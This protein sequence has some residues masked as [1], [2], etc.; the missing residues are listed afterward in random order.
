MVLMLAGMGAASLVF[1]PVFFLLHI[2]GIEVFALPAARD[3]PLFVANN[4]LVVGTNLSFALCVGIVSPLFCSIAS[5]LALPLTSVVDY[6]LHGIRFSTSK[7]IGTGAIFAG[8]AAMLL[9]E[10]LQRAQRSR[11][12]R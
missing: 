10:H 3:W 6:A 4:F 9:A 12:V 2:S 8:F 5:M 11:A 7:V 1:L